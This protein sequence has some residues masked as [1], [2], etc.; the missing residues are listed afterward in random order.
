MEADRKPP[1]TLEGV[2]RLAKR[3]KRENGI[4]H[5]RA[6]NRAAEQAGFIDFDDA[7]RKL[8]DRDQ[9]GTTNGGRV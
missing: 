6:L 8:A 3:L 2:K 9:A 4:T 1:T 7:R 5:T